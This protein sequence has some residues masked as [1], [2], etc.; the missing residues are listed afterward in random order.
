MTKWIYV[1]VRDN[2]DENFIFINPMR[3]SESEYKIL[4]DYDSEKYDIVWNELCD[5]IDRI[6]PYGKNWY[7]DHIGFTK[8]R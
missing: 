7:I 3:V 8:G 6:M 2:D 1:H 4:Q 5:K